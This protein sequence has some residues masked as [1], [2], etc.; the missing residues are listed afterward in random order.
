MYL[1]DIA[2]RN[3][4]PIEELALKLPFDGEANPKPVILMGANGSGK[5][6]L[7]SI[8]AD[9]LHEASALHYSDTTPHR[10]SVDRP[11]FRVVGSN[12][13]TWGRPGAYSVLRF[14]SGTDVFYFKERAGTYS[15]T[16]ARE[17][18][19]EE[20][21]P[22]VTWGDENGSLKAFQ[23]TADQIKNTF[24]TGVY[25]FFPSS[26]SEA[27]AWMNAASV[28]QDDFDASERFTRQL[29]KPIYLPRGMPQ[30]KQ[31]LLAL[32]VDVRADVV[33][34]ADEAGTTKWAM[35]GSPASL[36]AAQQVWNE[37]NSI[38][39]VVLNDESARFVWQGRGRGQGLRVL[40][41]RGQS[42][43][44][45]LEALSAGQATVLNIFCTLLRYG[46]G[47][48]GTDVPVPKNIAGICLIDEIDAHMH[49]DLQYRALPNLI[50]M[51]PRVQFVLSSHSPLFALGTELAFGKDGVLLVDMPSGLPIEAEAYSEFGEAIQA[52][53]A[54]RQFGE[55]VAA[56]VGALHKPVV[57]L[58][59]E[60]DPHYLRASAKL[61]GRAG[62]LDRVDFEWVGAKDA[63]GQ[64]FNT[65]SKALDHALSLFRA[66]PN[67]VKSPIMLLYDSDVGKAGDAF[68]FVRVESMPE[69]HD[70][71]RVTKGIE[72]LLSPNVLSAEMF[73]T[74]ET[75]QADGG[76]VVR[77]ALRKMDLCRQ[78]CEVEPSADNFAAFGAVLDMIEG[79]LDSLPSATVGDAS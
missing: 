29:G 52:F 79:W 55:R 75:S 21:T 20:L 46:D 41:G 15:G 54:T 34:Y 18:V 36:E 58:E 44:L 45:R 76:S 31:W 42:Q 69:N 63:G 24:Q 40:R 27:P 70:N 56:H 73:Q 77:T 51:F 65:G 74:T 35:A 6:N 4:G 2:L 14:R 71:R 3:A 9:A 62:L 17:E 32:M 28:A 60:T 23:A 13:V 49:L 64:G 37:V 39:R 72:N 7:L 57:L 68:G 48:T 5:T 22:A 59:G 11:W 8:V 33:G 53:E 1:T 30:L 26:R 47:T 78:A 61:L 25:A 19:P 12:T 10:S 50:R 67:L 66:K 16:T 38:L 43:V